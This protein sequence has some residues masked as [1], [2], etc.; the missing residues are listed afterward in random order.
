MVFI[1]TELGILSPLLFIPRRA[2][3]GLFHTRD[4]MQLLI[5]ANHEALEAAL[6]QPSEKPDTE[7]E[8]TEL[9]TEY[10]EHTERELFRV[11]RVFRGKKTK[12]SFH[13]CG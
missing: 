2:L 6:P 11:F 10:T 4:T 9:T 5:W 12:A 3:S 7:K 1:P 8:R 13:D